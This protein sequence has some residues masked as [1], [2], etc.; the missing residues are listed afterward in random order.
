[1][2]IS[3]KEKDLLLLGIHKLNK[4]L[5]K[6]KAHRTSRGNT[7]SI[8]IRLSYGS[9]EEVRPDDLYKNGRKYRRI[10]Y[11]TG[12]TIKADDWD[13]KKEKTKNNSYLNAQIEKGIVRIKEIYSEYDYNGKVDFRTLREAIKNDVQLNEIF[14][15]E[16]EIIAE[17][18]YIPPME[19]IRTYID[20]AQV[21][22]GT[23]K[24]YNNTYNH[25]EE[26]QVYSG[27]SLSWKSMGY[28]FYLD[29]VEFLKVEKD[30]KGSTIDKVI[31]NVKVFLNY[32]DLQDNLNVNQDFKK[33]VSG[34]SLFAKVNKE[35]AEHVYLNEKEIKQITDAKLDENL[36][37][38]RDLFLIGCW[39]GLRISDLKRLEKG[40]IKDGL[41]SITAQKTSKNVTIPI[42]DELQAVLDKYP[43]RLP[44][45]PTDQ[46]YNRQLK[47]VCEQAGIN[48][49][50]MAEEK[51]GK[52]R[53]TS[54]IPKW[55]LVTSH[56]ARRSF[57][58]NLY[59]RGIPSTQLMMLTG[60]K[61]E[62]SFM[63]YIKVSGEDN[64][65]DVAKK[66]KKLG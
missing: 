56:T 32:A 2:K 17:T 27:K 54:L 62:A 51:K 23:K 43:D 3:V 8:F 35:E 18:D 60:H 14:N 11:Y 42:T 64:A 1:V 5:M 40:N 15:K 13:L 21:T 58:T 46:H 44:K 29:L 10:E 30:L 20:K 9:Y 47:D 7:R 16:R 36:S 39:T 52:M 59:R 19:F 57:A 34:K 63:R 22:A 37:G 66:L 55:K 4:C 48:E 45:I 38:I 28:E 50:I 49:P 53:V 6:V 65:K 31:K 41:L 61:S 33:T 25:L 24:D 12:K 26:F